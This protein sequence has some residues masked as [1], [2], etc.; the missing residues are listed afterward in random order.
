MPN[1]VMSFPFH[2]SLPPIFLIL[3]FHMNGFF[4]ISFPVLVFDVHVN[5]YFTAWFCF[6]VSLCAFRSN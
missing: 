2:I 1:P 5:F 3:D 6:N 4:C